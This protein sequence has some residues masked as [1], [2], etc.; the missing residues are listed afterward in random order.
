MSHRV[1]MQF[2]CK[3]PKCGRIFL[4]EDLTGSMIPQKWKY[5]TSCVEEYKFINPD[6]PIKKQISE[7]QATILRENSFSKGSN[8]KKF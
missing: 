5:C 1:Y 6:K 8:R 2:L 3:N 4:D 7:N